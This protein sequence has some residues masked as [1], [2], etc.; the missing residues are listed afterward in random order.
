MGKNETI[1]PQPVA[2]PRFERNGVMCEA[3]PEPPGHV[4]LRLHDGSEERLTLNDFRELPRTRWHL[5]RDEFW[6]LWG[7][8]A[9]QRELMTYLYGEETI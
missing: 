4:V 5:V 7:G 2:F 8:N 1:T 3:V 6:D 9:A